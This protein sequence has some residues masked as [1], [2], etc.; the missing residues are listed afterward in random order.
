MIKNKT[1]KYSIIIISIIFIISY[2]V[3][4]SGYYEYQL[5]ERTILTNEKIKEFE[6]DVK[7]KEAID[8]KEY[9]VSEEIDYS[10]KL[11]NLV[12]QIS[13]NSNK[14]ARK[15]LKALFKKLSYLVED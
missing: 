14:L 5:Q 11:T 6:Q 2:F 3:S 12:Y 1:V 10:N 15:G 9:L 8:I 7:N 4:Y 13:D